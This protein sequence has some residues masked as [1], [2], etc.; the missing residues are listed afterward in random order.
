M[1]GNW[2]TPVGK[3]RMQGNEA[4]QGRIRELLLE[5]N[6]RPVVGASQNRQEN[7]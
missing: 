5:E 2:M 6:V 7:T 1:S 4:R 3:K